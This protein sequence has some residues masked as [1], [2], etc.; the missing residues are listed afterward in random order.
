MEV[1]PRLEPAAVGVGR[2][3]GEQQREREAREAR[4]AARADGDRGEPGREDPRVPRGLVD[5]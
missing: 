3:R 4:G 1:A 5:A 2:P